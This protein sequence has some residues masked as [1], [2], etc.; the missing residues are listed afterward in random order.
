MEINA[1]VNAL[2]SM[3]GHAA[4]GNRINQV[5]KIMSAADDIKR[6]GLDGTNAAMIIATLRPDLRPI[7]SLFNGCQ[8]PACTSPYDSQGGETAGQDD[9][10]QYNRPLQ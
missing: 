9:C 7:L 4:A 3:N 6:N 10:V 1:I 8:K 2:L 5:Q